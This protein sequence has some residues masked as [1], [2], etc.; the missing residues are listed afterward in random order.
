M[1]S[2]RKIWISRVLGDMTLGFLLEAAV[3]VVFL[4][5]A[6]VLVLLVRHHM[7][8]QALAE[9]E[10]KSRIILDRNLATHTY[11]THQLKPGLF[12]WSE[13]F[14]DEGYFDPVW[15]SST[16]AVREIDETFQSLNPADYY[17]K[18]CAIDARSPKNE[19]DAFEE[20]FIEELNQNPELTERSLVRSL[21]G[22]PAFVTLRRGETMEESCLRCHSTPNE[23]PAELVETYG[24]DR[25]FGR[26]V[27]EV[28][29][30]IS[31]RIP[32][33]EAYL[34]ADR[35]AGR[36]SL[37]LL[38][39]LVALFA[40]Q[41]WLSQ[42]FVLSPVKQIR[43]KALRI[44]DGGQHLGEQIP[45]PPGRDLRELTLAFNHM[46]QALRTS[47]ERL[48]ERVRTR[49]AELRVANL[50]LEASERKLREIFE[51]SPITIELYDGGGK[52]I[53]AN[54]AC[55][56]MFGVSSVDV[57]RGFRLF[58]DPNVP[59]EARTSLRE[60]RTVRYETDFDFGEVK[61]RSLYETCKAGQMHLDVLITPLGAE[62][63]ASAH[64]YLVLAQ[65]VTNQKQMEDALATYREHLEVLVAERTRELQRAQE[66]LLRH[67]KLAMVGQLAGSINHELRGPLGNIKNG[68]Y[69]L[70]M[71]LDE[72]DQDVKETLEIID[73]NVE[74]ANSIV[75]SLLGFVR[76]ERPE[77]EEIDV[78]RLLN[79]VLGHTGVNET[80][81]VST[82]M[83]EDLPTISASPEQLRRIFR[84][85]ITNALEAMPGGGRL[86]VETSRVAAADSES[87]GRVRI[88]IRD[89]GEGIPEGNRDKVFEPLFTTKP[90]GVGLGLALVKMLVEAHG[91]TVDVESDVG[92]GSVFHIFLPV[93][94]GR[95]GGGAT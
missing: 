35:F 21:D 71:V 87:G 9:A 69:I 36:L 17:Y 16:Y 73:H 43:K 66:K 7:R 8:K 27:G 15:M 3:A 33:E 45:L 80:I 64:G 40:A 78:N 14:R 28:V 44:A 83:D 62:E 25:S 13:P 85:L 37:L 90:E 92:V 76:T 74:R 29:S 82:R 89:T 46:S 42:S 67:E 38:A 34:D 24:G 6:V 20:A 75:N 88:S 26:E 18:E 55:L 79:D 19:A 54:P 60:G 70:D 4:V 41:S 50:E 11:F 93:S 10:S 57:I 63:E 1:N 61:N 12:D 95:H 30:A 65:D 91:G 58:E 68:A 72:P 94:R 32:L 51:A 5:G 84:N 53:D 59:D 22:E 49:T 52:L 77:R 31:I 23:A 2:D 56:S 48:E 86:T 47:Y 39:L 81:Q